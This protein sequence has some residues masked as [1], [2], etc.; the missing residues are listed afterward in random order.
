VQNARDCY[1]RL[2]RAIE[3]SL[4]IDEGFDIEAFEKIVRVP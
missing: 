3:M 4:A 2:L 1:S